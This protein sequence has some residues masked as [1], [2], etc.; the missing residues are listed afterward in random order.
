MD[1]IDSAKEINQ[2]LADIINYINTNKWDNILNLIKS[3]KLN[4]CR[5]INI[6]NGNTI[7]KK[8]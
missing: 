2:L 6:S 5:D 3:S 8:I 1:L 4:P 7:I